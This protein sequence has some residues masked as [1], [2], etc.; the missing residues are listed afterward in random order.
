MERRRD[1]E[2]EGEGLEERG[3]EKV[4]REARGKKYALQAELNYSLR[5]WSCAELLLHTQTKALVVGVGFGR[6]DEGCVRAGLY[7]LGS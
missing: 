4:A 5:S 2:R 3:S 7:A 6:V 1:E